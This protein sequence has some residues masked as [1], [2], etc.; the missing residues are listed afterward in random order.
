MTLKRDK[1]NPRLTVVRGQEASQT[2][3]IGVADRRKDV[4]YVVQLPAW[5]RL[6]SEYDLPVSA[7]SMPVTIPPHGSVVNLSSSG[8]CC[9]VP[10]EQLGDLMRIKNRA[11]WRTL[12][13][14]VIR[15]QLPAKQLV[16]IVC[17]VAY[18]RRAK[19]D[20]AE[21]GVCFQQFITGEQQLAEYIEHLKQRL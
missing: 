11:D 3:Q 14:V 15:F 5:I 2:T 6:A 16:S 8:L 10:F 17:G 19:V 20:H 13:P 18:V 9:I 1:S 4:R 21:V 12:L 7:S